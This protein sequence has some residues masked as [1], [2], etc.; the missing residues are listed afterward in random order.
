MRSKGFSRFLKLELSLFH[1]LVAK[2]YISIFRFGR[3]STSSKTTLNMQ[4]QTVI[5]VN[6][7]S[8]SNSKNE[9]VQVFS[10]LVGFFLTPLISLFSLFFVKS[11]LSRGLIIRMSGFCGLAWAG[12][13][14]FLSFL[15]SLPSSTNE[16]PYVLL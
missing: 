11:K 6:Q 1:L 7:P 9:S 15:S 16:I 4:Q 5:I 2:S 13:F 12:L 14:F 10:C 3:H 8:R